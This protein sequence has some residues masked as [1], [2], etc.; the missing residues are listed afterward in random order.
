MGGEI[1]AAGTLGRG[2]TFWFTADLGV[3]AVG[4][5]RTRAPPPCGA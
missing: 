1:G 2:S 5:P 4:A 3:E